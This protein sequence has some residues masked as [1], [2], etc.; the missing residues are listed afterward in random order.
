MHYDDIFMKDKILLVINLVIA[1][2]IDLSCN[3]VISKL[4]VFY[5]KKITNSD[6]YILTEKN[7]QYFSQK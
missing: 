3:V 6:I 7:S 5:I 1:N 4:K 2:E